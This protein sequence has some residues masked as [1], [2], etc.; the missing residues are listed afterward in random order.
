[1]KNNNENKLI[2][3][4]VGKNIAG[5]KCDEIKGI[6]KID[7]VVLSEGKRKSNNVK[8]RITLKNHQ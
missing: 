3:K 4:V 8:R 1:M 5:S 2:T 7:P 6:Q